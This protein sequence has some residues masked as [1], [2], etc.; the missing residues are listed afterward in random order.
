ML[1][2][3]KYIGAPKIVVDSV[4]ENITKFEVQYL[5]RGFWHTLGNAIRRIMLGY[6][7]WGAVTG[8]K[9]KWVSHEYQVIDWVQESVVDMML[10]IKTLR[11]RVQDWWDA[12]QWISQK[13]SWIGSYTSADI[14]LPAGIEILDVDTHLFELTDPNT[15]VELDLRIEKGYG[16][17]TIDYLMNREKQEDGEEVDIILI[18]NDFRLVD[19]VKYEVVEV[20][21]DFVWNTKDNLIIEVKT[22]Y[23]SISPKDFVAFAWEVLASYAKLFIFEDI[24]IDKSVLVEL[25][26]IKSIETQTAEDMDIKTMP[27]DALPLSERTRNALIKNNIL[28]VEDLEKKKK[29]ELLLMKWVWRK[30]IEEISAALSNIDKALAG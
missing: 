28:Y 30:A 18:D 25:N 27:I 11:F 14:K 3:Q 16:Y 17:Y 4:T 10:N 2:I 29:G 8:M 13:F 19:Y 26:E 21:D 5:P 15:T 22:K 6:D 23:S 7:L 9:I 24:Y 12:L 1:D 20:I